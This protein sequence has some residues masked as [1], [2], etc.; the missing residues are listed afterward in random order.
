MMTPASAD[1]DILARLMRRDDLLPEGW[2]RQSMTY[3]HRLDLSLLGY[4]CERCRF[5][6]HWFVYPLA[7]WL[8]MYCARR[9]QQAAYRERHGQAPSVSHAERMER[10][11]WGQLKST[12]TPPPPPTP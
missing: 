9:C 4:E 11:F 8:R 7:G 1:P 3:R 2:A 5:C 12:P 10:M 6:G